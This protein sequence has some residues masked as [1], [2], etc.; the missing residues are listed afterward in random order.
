MTAPTSSDEPEDSDG[1]ETAT[2]GVDSE[3]KTDTPDG[4]D[5]PTSGGSGASAGDTDTDSHWTMTE[6]DG[7]E[8]EACDGGGTR[9]CFMVDEDVTTH[10][11]WG[12][13]GECVPGDR[14]ECDE[15][16][17]VGTQ[18]CN[19]TALLFDFPE[20]SPPEVLASRKGRSHANWRPPM[21][22][23]GTAPVRASA[24]WTTTVCLG[25]M[26]QP[27]VDV[28]VDAVTRH[29]SGAP[30]VVR[31]RRAFCQLQYTR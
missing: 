8:Q 19:A 3:P 15:D 31:G 4:D 21:T 29:A 2:D 20:G 12:E 16:G 25:G 14:Q 27:A 13:C 11:V 22:A 24:F 6:C 10:E 18:F 26:R 1:P 9:F 30:S 17:E 28:R 7:G 23:R 5:N